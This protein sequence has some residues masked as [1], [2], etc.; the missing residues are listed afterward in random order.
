MTVGHMKDLNKRLI[1][2]HRLEHP[3]LAANHSLDLSSGYEAGTVQ[4][5]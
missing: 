5:I 2:R 4:Q 3:V 1:W